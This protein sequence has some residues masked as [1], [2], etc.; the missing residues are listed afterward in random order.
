MAIKI[1]WWKTSSEPQLN[2]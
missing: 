2:H 1:K